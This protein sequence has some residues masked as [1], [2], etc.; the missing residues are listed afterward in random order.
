MHSEQLARVIETI[1]DTMLSV[2][3][4]RVAQEQA[5]DADALTARIDY[6]GDFRGALS[7]TFGQPLAIA[8]AGLMMGRSGRS[9]SRE[10]VHDAIGEIANIAAGNLRGLLA[11]RC[12]LSLPVVLEGAH[13]RE[14]SHGAILARAE[15]TLFARPLRAELRECAR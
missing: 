8:L 12:A 7:I 1:A 9:C 15:F 11:P 13:A 6:F 14:R 10:D 5:F 3:A 2:P 4:L